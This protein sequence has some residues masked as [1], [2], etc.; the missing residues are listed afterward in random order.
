MSTFIEIFLTVFGA[1]FGFVFGFGLA[2]ISLFFTFLGL[3]LC[4]GWFVEFGHGR[5]KR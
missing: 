3:M 2:G 4:F 5:D 1:V